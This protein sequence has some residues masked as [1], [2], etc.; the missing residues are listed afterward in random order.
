M[1]YQG[2]IVDTWVWVCREDLPGSME[3]RIPAYT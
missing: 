2:L 3:E 1:G